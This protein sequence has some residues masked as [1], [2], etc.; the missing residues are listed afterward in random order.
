MID[1]TLAEETAASS[2]DESKPAEETTPVETKAEEE[3]KT[4]PYERF[5]E[6]INERNQYR[7]L[8]SIQ[9]ENLGV[10]KTTKST[11][12]QINEL[13][14][15]T[16]ASYDEALKLIDNRVEEKV[17]RKLDVISRQ[18]E[19]DKT[20]RDN[21]D[22]FKYAEI[23]KENIK[24]NPYLNWA[25]A[26]KLARYDASLMQAKEQGKK[27]AYQKIEEKKAAG[28]EATS[29]AKALPTGDETINPLSKG[30]DGKFL[31]SIKELKD[32][33]PKQI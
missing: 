13:E 21:P 17:S 30:P 22:F 26:Y 29:K 16:G 32:I 33:L 10:A 24:A 6:V 11:D 31:Y 2:S 5:K 25:D 15:Q 20:I 7:D 12:E 9:Q 19:L 3:D 4:V 8:L 28:V 18:I 27:E 1:E 23:I 14:V